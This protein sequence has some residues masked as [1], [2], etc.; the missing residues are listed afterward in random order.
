MNALK[1]ATR[2]GLGFSSVLLL[3][4]LLG[5][6]AIWNMNSSRV[7]SDE[8]AHLRVPE[9]REANDLERSSLLT[10]YAI[11]GYGLSENNQ[12]LQDGRSFLTEVEGSLEDLREFAA[13]NKLEELD[14]TMRD[15]A[16]QVATYRNLVEQTVD[17][18][19][20]INEVRGQMDTAAA[21]FMKA[22]LAF[23]ERQ[24]QV[25]AEE[26]QN[27]QTG[28]ANLERLTKIT[29]V[30]NVIDAGNAARLIAWRA[31]AERAPELLKE[32]DAHFKQIAETLAKLRPITHVAVDIQRIDDCERAAKSYHE[33]LEEL[34]EEWRKLQELAKRRDTTGQNVLAAAQRV[35]RNGLDR[36]L[37]DS[38]SNARALASSTIWVA[39][40]LGLAMA[41]GAVLAW[42]IT[43][44]IVRPVKA[45]AKGLTE[46]AT[47]D[48]TVRVAISSRDEIGELASV[49]NDMAEALEARAQLATR[50]GQGDL[51]QKVR[52]TSE[53]D[54][55][56]RALQAMIKNL[57]EIVGDVSA[58]AA[59]VATGSEQINSSSQDISTGASQQAASVEEVAASMEEAT[60]N[61]RTSSDNARETN[62]ISTKA[63][64]DAL[65]AGQ[66]V[67]KTVGAM[68]DI[69]Q[70]TSIIEEIARQTD[71]LA[72]NAAIEA[73]RAGEHGKG[74]AV[75]ASEV[76]KLAE[77]SQKA[78]GEI[79]QLSSSSV[80]IAENA[81]KMLEKLVP[82]IR[83][84]AELVKEIAV[85]S[86][87]Q[88]R[89]AEQINRAIQ[90]LDKVIQNNAA[91]AEEMA[92]SATELS[93]Q[94]V[95]LQQAIA[96][97]K[98]DDQGRNAPS[99]YRRAEKPRA[100]AKVL[101]ANHH[102]LQTARFD[103]A[104]LEEDFNFD[105]AMAD[106]DTDA[107]K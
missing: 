98:I 66:S 19:A 95:A 4:L 8:I 71:L 87:E 28:D 69:A 103:H 60:A 44:A 2:I 84:T 55:L 85:S 9:V 94:G 104:A 23:L 99:A 46:I 12:Y 33:A 93:S 18:N 51:R 3:T 17:G 30:N 86:D 45:L 57:S 35:A 41:L 89:G 42:L 26:I 107:T 106:W 37:T 80:E 75:V 77:R 40:G 68:K 5:S 67:Q 34:G 47:G 1:L 97:F 11:R 61:I 72:L 53:K 15:T 50:I 14:A 49:A 91:S 76:R 52:L 48:L 96:F 62:K 27:G 82:D 6:F 39:L 32:T 102:G 21:S 100:P 29:Y 92:A 88:G 64:T 36:S 54:V 81:G 58:S 90:E 10:M 31:Q 70:K 43:R 105:E 24:N 22:S 20:R 13:K 25:F 56:G 83:R 74:F 7:R 65:E 73:A 16:V 59:N 38:D 63:A 78:A 101:S 79:S